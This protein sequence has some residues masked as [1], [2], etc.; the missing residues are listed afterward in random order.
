MN[1]RCSRGFCQ[2]ARRATKLL[3]G[4]L[5]VFFPGLAYQ[6]GCHS[7]LCDLQEAVV[8]NCPVLT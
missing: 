1:T 4:Y 8:L 5:C 3:R 2:D 6:E 7:K